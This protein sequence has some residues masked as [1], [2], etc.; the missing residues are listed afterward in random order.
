MSSSQTHAYVRP[1]E[2]APAY[3]CRDNH[4]HFIP[5]YNDDS[6][7]PRLL[8]WY[9]RKVVSRR[10]ASPL[11][12]PTSKAVTTNT[13]DK[14][15]QQPFHAGKYQDCFGPVYIQGLGGAKFTVQGKYVSG[16]YYLR[17]FCEESELCPGR[18]GRNEKKLW[19]EEE[20]SATPWPRKQGKAP[21]TDEKSPTDE[22][23]PTHRE[24]SSSSVPSS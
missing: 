11:S 15:P 2:A 10:L 13:T 21:P 24:S 18:Y 6:Q 7:D 5:R 12:T 8:P 17:E 16:F 3:R 22:R 14:L 23:S 9:L 4:W 19:R 20:L 1:R